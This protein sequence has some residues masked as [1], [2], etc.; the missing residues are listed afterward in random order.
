MHDSAMI[1][2]IE[3]FFVKNFTFFIT[4]HC[5]HM[6]FI[7]FDAMFHLFACLSLFES[8][9]ICI[10]RCFLISLSFSH[11]IITCKA[12]SILK[13]FNNFLNNLIAKFLSLI[14]TMLQELACLENNIFHNVDQIT[15][16][17]NI[18]AQN[19]WYTLKQ[20]IANQMMTQSTW[21]DEQIE[22]FYSYVVRDS[23]WVLHQTRTQ[24]NEE[25]KQVQKKVRQGWDNESRKAESRRDIINDWEEQNT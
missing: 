4:F 12:R 18:I 25:W 7:Q 6:I 1:S 11:L 15:T 2:Q 21:L 3:R 19:S 24:F 8:S 10:C 23:S 13:F 17:L 22:Q 9:N 5:F 20:N 14:I 16:Y